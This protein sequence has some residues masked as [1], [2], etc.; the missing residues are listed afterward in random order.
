MHVRIH[1]F[2]IA[3]VA[4]TLMLSATA[5]MAQPASDSRATA[6]DIA[7]TP[8]SGF[9]DTS[10]A[11][12]AADEP[13][14][15]CINIPPAFGGDSVWYRYA[16]AA[17]ADLVAD[18]FGS[19]YDTVLVVWDGAAPIGCN[20]DTFG[21]QS[22]VGFTAQA[23]HTYYFQVAFWR[24]YDPSGFDPPPFLSFQL[25]PPPPPFEASAT[26][27]PVGRA[28]GATGVVEIAGTVTC[29]RPGFVNAIVHIQQQHGRVAAAALFL[30]G[31]C[32][33]QPAR[34]I[35]RFV[36]A[37]ARF[38]PGPVTVTVSGTAE[39]FPFVGAPL[40]A[41]A[42]VRLQGASAKQLALPPPPQP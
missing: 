22:Q 40:F 7:A 11:T 21:L 33:P 42:T 20:D 38:T 17:T 32:G 14:P 37:N 1:R 27:D 13:A 9:T 28:A 5:A 34:A 35:A 4:G 8:F 16:P 41:Q 23:G 19:N 24:E 29:N 26:L 6:T 36:G 10:A 31:P 15:S 30:Q 25:A 12:T 18:T 3:A 2:S 39:E